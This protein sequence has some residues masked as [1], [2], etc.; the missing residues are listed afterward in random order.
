MNT[1]LYKLAQENNIDIISAEL[2]TT[3]SCSVRVDGEY[4]IGM[5]SA[6]YGPEERIH[7]AHELGHC[8]S[9]AMYNVY[10]PLDNRAKHELRAEQ[11]S[12]RRLI[13]RDILTDK[14]AQGYNAW[15]IADMLN[16][17]VRYVSK[18]YDMYR[19]DMYADIQT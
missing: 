14:L 10:A 11:W 18:A 13:P 17:P 16:V 6:L 12:L 4:Y 8:M 19:S 3:E 9:G 1:D 5:D 7:L 15:D 2:P